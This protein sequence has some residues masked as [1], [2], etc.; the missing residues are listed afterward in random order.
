MKT[1]KINLT[2]N[3]KRGYLVLSFGVMT[4]FIDYTI[5]KTGFEYWQTIMLFCVANLIGLPGLLIHLYYLLHDFRIALKYDTEDDYFDFIKNSKN[6]RIY[7]KDVESL[8]KITK[9]GTMGIIPW[10]QYKMFRIKLK[11]GERFSVT[12]LTIDFDELFEIVKMK[13]RQLNTYCKFRLF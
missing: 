9:D 3:I 7:K 5:I 6:T 8:D 4:L 12:N 10:G 1:Y 2:K 13:D 11:T